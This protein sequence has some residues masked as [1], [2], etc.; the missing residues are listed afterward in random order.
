MKH[1]P[2]W[3]L[4]KRK[5]NRKS[6]CPPKYGRT[7]DIEKI[8]PIIGITRNGPKKIT[9]ATRRLPLEI[10]ANGKM[11]NCFSWGNMEESPVYH[12][13]GRLL[14]SGGKSSLLCHL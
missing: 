3:R 6:A 13:P 5:S 7:Q 14:A 1:F 4:Y 8:G 11:R 2:L 10:R 12:R 9:G